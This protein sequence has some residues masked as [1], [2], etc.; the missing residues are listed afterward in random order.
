[1][2][3]LAADLL[4]SSH[5]GFDDLYDRPVSRKHKAKIFVLP[6]NKAGR[7][8]SRKEQLQLLLDRLR[9][10]NETTRKPC[11]ICSNLVKP[12]LQDEHNAAY[13]PKIK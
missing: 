8:G 11:P 2:A 12:E 4:S 3:S 7:Y 1:M 5:S 6:T 13:H 10:E 9:H